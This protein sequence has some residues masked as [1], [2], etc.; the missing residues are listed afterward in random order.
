MKAKKGYESMKRILSALLCV[1]MIFTITSC[2]N[3]PASSQTASSVQ[4]QVEEVKEPEGFKVDGTKLLD[5]YGNEFVMRGV[6]FAYTWFKDNSDDALNG[7]QYVGCNAVRLVL[8]DGDQW[9]K[10]SKAELRNLIQKCKKRNLIAV[11]EIH[12]GTG[13]NDVSYLEHAVDYWI[14]VKDILESNKAYVIVNIANEWYG[15]YND[16][17][18]W[19]DA[20]IDAIKKLREAGITNTLIVDSAGWG[21]CADSIL[22]YGNEIFE[23]DTL[24]N[25]M[26]AVHM[27]G[28]AGKNEAL[29][30]KTID[31]ALQNNLCLLIGEFGYKHSDGDVDEETIMKY[32]TEKNVGYFAWSWKGNN[33]D[34]AY[35]DVSRDWAG[36]DL[37][38]E[39]G[40]LLVNG[41]YG[42]KATSE[43]CSVFENDEATDSEQS[44]AEE[45]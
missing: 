20:Y 15:G 6:N 26:F 28:T 24:A 16:L 40:E 11:L 31:T 34:V 22:T 36:T 25:T 18:T 43:I 7:M 37:T 19:R 21:Q 33:E 29:I 13:K 14:D 42:I 9:D 41:E 5:G 23:A 2:S 10:T 4:S 30:K 32:T 17:E 44:Q 38:P 12:D 8:S 35:L 3:A 27:Y 45:E 1:A 39:W